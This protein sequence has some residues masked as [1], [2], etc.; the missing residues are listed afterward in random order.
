MAVGGGG[1]GGDGGGEGRDRKVMKREEKRI[2]EEQ[3]G[4][5]ETGTV[6]QIYQI[7]SSKTMFRVADLE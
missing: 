6:S 7:W 5:D 4:C 3:I 2:D 1:G